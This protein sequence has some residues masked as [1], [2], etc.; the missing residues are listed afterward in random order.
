MWNMSSMDDELVLVDVPSAE[1]GALSTS[2]GKEVVGN[3]QGDAMEFLSWREAWKVSE[4]RVM[5][6]N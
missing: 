6:R 4:P 2:V 5:A 3:V 1:R